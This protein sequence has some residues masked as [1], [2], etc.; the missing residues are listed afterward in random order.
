MHDLRRHV[1][2]IALGWDDEAPG[3]TWRV[4]DGTL[5]FADVS[6]FTAL[7]ERLSRRGRIGAEDIVET[8]NGV[9]SPMIGVCAC[10]GGELLKFGGDALLFLFRGPDH[11]EQACDAAVEMR[12]G[13]ARAREVTAS[14]GR[15]RLSMSVG[16]HTGDLHLFLVGSP[17]REL[18]VLGPGASSTARAEKAA[19]AGEIVLSP[20]TVA[21]LGQGASRPR[22]DGALLL[23]RRRPRSTP[24]SPTPV[25]EATAARLA[26]LFPHALGSPPGPRTPGP[27]APD[28]DDRLR[29]LLRHRRRARRAR[30]A[31]ARRPPR[32]GRRRR[33]GRAGSRGPEPARDRPRHRRGQVLPR[34]RGAGEPGRRRGPDAASAAAH[35]RHPAPPGAAARGEPRSRLRRGGG[36]CPARG[37]LGDGR[38]HEH[39]GPDHVGRAAGRPVRT[40][41]RPRPLPH[42]VRDHP[43]RAVHP[44][45]EGRTPAGP[46]GRARD[47]HEGG[48]RRRPPAAARPRQ[49][50]AHGPG[51]PEPGP[52]GRRRGR[53]RPRGGGPGQVP[54]GRR[55]AR[56]HAAGPDR[57]PARRAVR[58][59][60]HLPGAPGPDARSARGAAR[61][62]GADGCRPPG[63]PAPVGP[64]PRAAGAAARRRRAGRRP[65]HPGRRTDRPGVPRRPGRRHGHRGARPARRRP[66]RRRRRRR[67]LGGRRL[68]APPGPGRDRDRGTPV[69]AGVR[70]TRQRGRSRCRSTAPR[71]TSLRSRTRS[72]SGS[73]MPRPSPRPCARTRPRRWW[74]APPG[75][76]STSR[77]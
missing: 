3:T 68:G 19:G 14:G 31:G 58:G 59:D 22:A 55:G 36:V 41:G 77:R 11:A 39:R 5:V 42:D 75:A 35:R 65:H 27:G 30:P 76:R 61:R 70:P 13:L 28:S 45:G 62:P 48:R 73:S 50:A 43:R 52:R 8:L 33:G 15:L 29:L 51:G 66:V 44:Q 6:G 47:R 67:A 10:R 60:E 57:G 54:A 7:T 9:F 24:G 74:R 46:R 18:L 26:T 37:L 34:L 64:G 56:L 21:R 1:P 20:G 53:R 71:W 23:R 2:P 25:P 63:H 12:S 17:T 69:G 49:R 32:R 40:P 38:H 16:V 4:L 72:S